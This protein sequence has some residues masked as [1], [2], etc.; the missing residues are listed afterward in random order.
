MTHDLSLNIFGGGVNSPTN[1][2][3]SQ[4]PET[5]PPLERKQGGARLPTRHRHRRAKTTTAQATH[6]HRTPFESI[7]KSRAH[8]HYYQAR[9]MGLVCIGKK[10]NKTAKLYVHTHAFQQFCKVVS[11][12]IPNLRIGFRFSLVLPRPPSPLPPSS[13]PPHSIIRFSPIPCRQRSSRARNAHAR[14]V[15]S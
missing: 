4:E 7:R 14:L 8:P 1:N 11:R 2:Q 6:P 3:L 13:R 12:K 5:P 15:S 10:K 9:W